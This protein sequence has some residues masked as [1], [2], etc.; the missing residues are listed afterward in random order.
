V[1]IGESKFKITKLNQQI[2]L[3]NDDIEEQ[4][5]KQ[6]HNRKMLDEKRT[7]ETELLAY[8]ETST[9]E[10]RE[11]KNN[12]EILTQENMKMRKELEIIIE[13]NQGTNT[14]IELS[15]QNI[16]GLESQLSSCRNQLAEVSTQNHSLFEK[17]QFYEN[18]IINFEKIQ[19]NSRKENQFIKEENN[20][21]SD[22]V[23]QLEHEIMQHIQVTKDYENQI[24]ALSSNFARCEEMLSESRNESSMLNTALDGARTLNAQLQN[25]ADSAS[26][27]IS[28]QVNDTLNKERICD[29]L[30]NE[31]GQIQI[32]LK[33]TQNQVYLLEATIRKL[34]EDLF[35]AEMKECELKSERDL[36]AEQAG[37]AHRQF[38]EVDQ[39]MVKLR[40]DNSEL[41]AE[42]E[43]LKRQIT[44]LKFQN[45]RTN[46]KLKKIQN[47]ETEND[48]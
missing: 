43:T 4:D 20:Q 40:C 22:K 16:N 46:Q 2:E 24:A 6:S 9:L 42:I 41:D 10:K 30:R 12:V 13:Q 17:V 19:E 35:E 32:Q 39:E 44:D 33:E 18:Q 23:I 1:V 25:N 38:E 27:E 14:Q 5:R 45:E 37:Q 11:L 28:L 36:F 8:R 31:I 29:D 3:L 7:I 21:L 26:R 34:R 48:T 15:K 47:R